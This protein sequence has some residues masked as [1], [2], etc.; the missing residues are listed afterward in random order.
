[1]P[2]PA[3]IGG[4]CDG[5][6]CTITS[7]TY[8]HLSVSRLNM[9]W[10]G[11]EGAGI[12]ASIVVPDANEVDD[13]GYA[14]LSIPNHILYQFPTPNS[15][16]TVEP[17]ALI[18]NGSLGTFESDASY[19]IGEFYRIT[20][21]RIERED[22]SVLVLSY[23]TGDLAG[24]IGAGGLWQNPAEADNECGDC[25][26]GDGDGWTDEL[27][28]DCNKD[29]SDDT[30]VE[31]NTTSSLTCNDGIDNDDDGVIDSEDDDCVNGWSGE[32]NC[33]NGIDD[34]GDGWIDGLDG[35]CDPNDPKA[36]E[37]GADDPTWTCTDGID[38]DGDGW[39]D[40]GD[41]GCALGSDQE[42][43]G[44]DTSLPCNDNID[45]DEDGLVDGADPFCGANGATAISESP[46]L[47]TFCIDGVDNDSDGFLD[48]LDPDC[49]YTPYSRENRDFH[50][51]TDETAPWFGY[52]AQCYDGL[53]NDGDGAVDAA[54]SSCWNPSAGF[55]PDGW[56]NDEGAIQLHPSLGT[57]TGCTDGLDNDA[58]GW[59]D[60][61][62]PDC[63]PGDA[64]QVEVGFG[65][66]ACNDGI[67][68]NN[69]GDIDAQDA[70]CSK[71]SDN[72][73]GPPS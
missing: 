44:F 71:G 21:Y 31:S 10:F 53:D 56:L 26:D 61:L 35:E 64:D 45:N 6:D 2:D 7:R 22:G 37:T 13:E 15:Q 70:D 48:A 54:D 1:M 36:V 41:P 18:D 23:A 39:I 8:V 72:F 34:D 17:S 30:T 43:D 4:T 60:G 20:D 63:Q 67:D 9:G 42:T 49:E 27:D 12:R 57:P 51:P 38:N 24:L 19:L 40:S 32:T 47:K 73:E 50:D 5:S 28:P 65:T 52:V 33:G 68:N 25:L 46:E 14:H 55:L 29:Y 3:A 62:D 69:D 66:T 59:L 11:G 58:D 16:W